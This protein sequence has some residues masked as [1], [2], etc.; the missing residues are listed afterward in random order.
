MMLAR[1]GHDVT[2]LE[3]DPDPVPGAP[4]D[5]WG[6]WQRKGVA[7][8]SQPHNLFGRFRQVCDEE[9]FGLTDRLLAAGC[10]WVDYL[11]TLPPTIS[12]QTPRPG[13]ERLR[14]VTGRRPVFEAA[15]AAAAADEPRV[16]VRRGVRVA[17]LVPGSQTANGTPHVAGV[18]MES[19]EEIAADLVVDAT[20]RRSPAPRWLAELGAREPATESEDCGFVYY[21]RY[22]GGPV[23]PQRIGRA[24]TPIGT[25]SVLTLDGDNDTWSVT[26][27]GTTGDAPIKNLRHSERFDRVIGACP[28][29]AHWLDGEPLTDVLPMAGVLDRYCRFSVD[30]RPVVTG[31]AA[32]GDSWACTNPSAGRGLSVGLVHAQLLRRT[33]RDA[34]EDRAGF[35]ELWD[36]RTEE[37]VAP[38]YWNQIADDRARVAEMNALREG[39]EP[40][41]DESIGTRF[42]AAA[43]YDPDLFRGLLETIQCLALPREVLARPGF[44]ET[45]EQYADAEARPSPG[46]DRRQLLELLEG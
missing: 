41:A 35:A 3:S 39:L 4:V 6:S 10:V 36:E 32:V 12:D 18:R 43:G 25:I 28:L 30:G 24:L 44:M 20:G 9:L 7:Q 22:F 26:V 17:G 31:F 38:F 45:I 42:A 23:R 40:P 46:P 21:T 5:A 33:V 14:F 15:I 16:T 19:G 1:D 11:E 8:F 34:L 13:D 27:F 29:Q 37:V 2:V